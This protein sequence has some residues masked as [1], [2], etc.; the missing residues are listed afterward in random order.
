MLGRLRVSQVLAGI[1]VITAVVLLIAISS[2]YK[3]SGEPAVLYVDTEESKAIIAE[4]SAK[5]RKK[6][7]D[8]TEDTEESEENTEENNNEEEVT[9][10]EDN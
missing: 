6:E 4:D 9:D 5:G 2:K 8:E 1:L 3:R 10:G 7:N